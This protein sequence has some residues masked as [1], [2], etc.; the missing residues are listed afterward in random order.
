MCEMLPVRYFYMI[1]YNYIFFYRIETNMCIFLV[2]YR[3]LHSPDKMNKNT[4]LQNNNNNNNTRS[5]NHNF[6]H[7]L[8][9]Q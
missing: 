8:Y 6:F 3:N 9:A 1:V 4:N 2:S 7:K 5:F